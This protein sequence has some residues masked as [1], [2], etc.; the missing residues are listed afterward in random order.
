MLNFKLQSFG[1]LERNWTDIEYEDKEKQ[2]MLSKFSSYDAKYNIAVGRHEKVKFTNYAKSYGLIFMGTA[3][4][5]P[6]IRK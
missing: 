1:D 2:I 5:L 3:F 4:F 6:V